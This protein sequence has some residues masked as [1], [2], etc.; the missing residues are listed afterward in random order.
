MMEMVF[1]LTAMTLL[2]G[3][4]KSS[5][6]ARLSHFP[7][8]EG[9]LLVTDEAVDGGDAN[10]KGADNM[11]GHSLAGRDVLKERKGG[12]RP[13]GVSGAEINVKR[14]SVGRDK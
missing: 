12:G 10:H 1:W 11:A 14:G 6:K 3:C 9:D 4:L 13:D 7:G 2:K 8:S 5:L